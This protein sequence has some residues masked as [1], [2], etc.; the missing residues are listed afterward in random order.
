MKDNKLIYP[1]KVMRITQSYD[2]KVSHKPHTQ[3]NIKDYPIDEGCDDG[4]RSYIYCPCEK[5]QV[6]RIYGVGTSGTNTIWL[7]SLSKVTF[8]DETQDYFTMM[9]IHPNDDDLKKI[10]VGDTFKKGEAICREGKDGATAYHFHISAG[11]GEMKGNGWAKNS[12]GKWVLTTTKGAFKPQDLFFVDESFTKVVSEAN[13]KFKRVTTNYAAGYYKVATSAL[14][15][16]KGP[17]T[18]YDKNGMV[19][20]SQKINIV[21]VK[22]N[23]GK[24]KDNKWICLDYC[25]VIK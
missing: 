4:G 17:G 10:K 7:Q 6:K 14:N 13:L 5:M 15:V 24:I 1:C 22:E 25:E 21:Q 2:G 9:I 20:L 11:K 19:Y 23:W 3:G 18:Q 16:R 12:K 8:A